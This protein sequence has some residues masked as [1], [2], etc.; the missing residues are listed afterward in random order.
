SKF[1]VDEV[2]SPYW[3]RLT[4]EHNL[5]GYAHHETYLNGQDRWVLGLGP[6]ITAKP[7]NGTL[8]VGIC[9]TYRGEPDFD[10]V[11][12]MTTVNAADVQLVNADGAFPE[13]PIEPTFLKGGESYSYFIV[14]Q[15][16]FRM[17]VTDA[18][19]AALQGTT[20][21]YFY[22][23]NGGVWHPSPDV[24]LIWRDYSA[25]F[26]KTRVDIDLNPIQLPG[27]IQGID[28][29]TDAVR[30]GS[31]DI[32]Y[33]VLIDGV[34]RSIDEY[35]PDAL[36]NLPPLLPMR[37][38]FVGTPDIMPGI[39]LDGSVVTVSRLALAAKHVAVQKNIGA[40]NKITV[41]AR[42]RGF[43][44]A[45]HNVVF[46]IDRGP[47]NL[48]LADL[49]NTKTLSDG[50]VEK[51]AV[52]NLAAPATAY[53]SSI[54]MTTDAATRPFVIIPATEVALP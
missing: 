46:K 18:Q 8:T 14:T 17:G 15:H 42:M 43:D 28:I 27:G 12:A 10:Q 40:S 51:V 38:T 6:H 47:G 34:W 32:V 45:H 23:M 35:S 37:V 7:A 48:E 20:G 2:A 22:G 21:T 36:A 24:H 33:S 29:L 41:T 19:T 50:T 1:W 9:R 13:I 44:P 31:T 30:P 3:S 53:E 26:P 4:S 39:R 16:P 49:V 54:E 11:L 52:F 5:L 25:S